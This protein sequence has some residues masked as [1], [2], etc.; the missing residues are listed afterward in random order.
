MVTRWNPTAGAGCGGADAVVSTSVTGAEGT[1]AEVREETPTP[2][3]PSLAVAAGGVQAV[4]W[5]QATKAPSV[6]IS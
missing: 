3:P 6:V 4:M 5:T 1:A 2:G